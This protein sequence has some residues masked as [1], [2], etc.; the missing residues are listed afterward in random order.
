VTKKHVLN[1]QSLK[2]LHA[3][4][5]KKP[6]GGVAFQI[7]AEWAIPKMIARIE[8]LEEFVD[9]VIRYEDCGFL[10]NTG[11]RGDAKTCACNFHYALRLM[12]KKEKVRT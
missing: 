8:E 12:G 3:G 7:A 10:Q 1:L 2:E 4:R 5:L 11:V 6:T 9:D